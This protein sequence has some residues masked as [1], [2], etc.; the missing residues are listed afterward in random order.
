MLNT[1]EFKTAPL[2]TK[3]EYR[4]FDFDKADM[5][6][7][8]SGVIRPGRNNSAPVSSPAYSTL[9]RRSCCNELLHRGDPTR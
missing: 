1:L 4:V 9:V 8:A 6:M 2:T 3:G 7:P 5:K